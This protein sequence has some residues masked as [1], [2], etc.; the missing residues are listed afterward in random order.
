MS[1]ITWPPALAEIGK[2]LSPPP[3]VGECDVMSW[4]RSR[5]CP[6]AKYL[7]RVT[8]A[9]Y[10]CHGDEDER[11]P[12][13]YYCRRRDL[14]LGAEHFGKPLKPWNIGERPPT[15]HE[16]LQLDERAFHQSMAAGDFLPGTYR[17]KTPRNIVAG[18]AAVHA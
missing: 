18:I 12:G 2:R 8:T 15:H 3:E 11:E 13:T 6:S 17:P 16:Q 5:H 14:F 10:Y 4:A 1:A 9:R 7:Q